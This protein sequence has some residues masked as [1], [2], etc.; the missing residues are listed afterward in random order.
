MSIIFPLLQNEYKKAYVF[1]RKINF[2][3]PK[4]YTGG[5]GVDIVKW[6]TLSSKKQNDALKKRWYVYYSF[7][8][9]E[10]GKFTRQ[11]QIKGGANTL[12]TK[13]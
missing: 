4:I 13:N 1:R 9:P 7:R 11:R 10:T 3:E 5:G 2:S 8:N 12:K 6:S